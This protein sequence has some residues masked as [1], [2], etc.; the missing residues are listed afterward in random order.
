MSVFAKWT[1][2]R[3]HQDLALTP[4]QCVTCGGQLF[5]IWCVTMG[6]FSCSS[7]KGVNVCYLPLHG[8][9]WLCV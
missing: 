9:V 8:S 4:G 5:S 1:N 3:D 7:D 6:A 2:L